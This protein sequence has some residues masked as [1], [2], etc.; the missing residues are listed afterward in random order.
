[1]K[2][3]VFV[4][5]CLILFVCCVTSF[6]QTD[7]S[8]YKIMNKFK[9]EGDG[10]WDYLTADDSTGRLFISHGTIV[11]VIDDKTGKLIGTIIGLNGVHGI[12]LAKDLNKGFISSGRDSSVTIINLKTLAAITKINVT[13]KN[14]DAI[15][16]EPS[17]Q[18]VFTFNGRSSNVTVIDA[19]TNAV[20][21]TIAV[22]GKPEFAVTDGKGSVYFNIEDK[23]ELSMINAKTLKV[24]KTWSVKP[25]EEPSGLAI[26]VANNIL[27]SVCDKVMVISD[28]AAGKVITTATI[29]DG[30][31]GVSFD[32]Y[33]KR[34]YSSNGDGTMTVVQEVSK[35]KFTVL[36]NVKTQK[37]ARTISV[38]TK[39]HHLFLP[40]AEY[41]E[42]PAATKEHP[43]P[44]PPIK[45][46][47]FVIL[48]IAPAK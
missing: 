16:Y 36:E 47:T 32:P 24:E 20:I 19:K 48:D 7:S 33:L 8:K 18:K 4:F 27:F 38:D 45:P 23:S 12:A 31:D 42:T 25:G 46:N 6:A 30:P 21:G 44:R 2:K 14:P 9:V 11:Q 1:M 35:D 28:A 26:D 15:L 13:G 10:G 17:T 40:A 29:G 43:K 41:G 37:G 34:A 5:S 3:I 22:D 39:T